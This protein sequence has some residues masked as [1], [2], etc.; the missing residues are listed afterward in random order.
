MT[1]RPVEPGDRAEFLRVHET[2]RSI[3][4]PW[5]PTLKPGETFEDLFNQMLQRREKELAN[6]TG[7]PLAGFLADGS[8][9]G[10]FSL[11]SIVRGVFWCAHAGWRVSADRMRQ[12]LGSEGVTALL[13]FAFAPEPAG[14]GLHRV[15]ANIIPSNTASIRLAEKLG[16]R[17]EGLALRYLHI[18][19]QWQDHVMFAKLSDE[20]PGPISSGSPPP[21]PSR[22]LS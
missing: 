16:F 12:G 20:H 5:M 15:Q 7:R 14:L 8:L 11:S 10:F 9:A 4:E 22:S 3:W 1:L 13:D 18:G 19:G 17:R 6:D 2:S 21:A